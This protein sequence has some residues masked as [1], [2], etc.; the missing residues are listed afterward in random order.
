MFCNKQNVPLAAGY[1]KAMARKRGLDRALTLSIL[2]PDLADRAGDAALLSALVERETDLVALS[3]YP[4]N[5]ARSLALAA[6]LR[7]RRPQLLVVA[8]GPEVNANTMLDLLGPGHADVAVHGEGEITFSEILEALLDGRDPADVPGVTTLRDGAVY[9]A[10][11]RPTLRDLDEIPSPFLSGDLDAN[12]W[13]QVHIL[14]ERGCVYACKYCHWWP[15]KRSR[16]RFSLQRIEEEL[17]HLRRTQVEEVILLDASINTSPDFAAL[18]DLLARVNGDGRLKIKVQVLYDH[19]TREQLEAMARG[20]VRR[21]EIGLQSANPIALKRAQR[22]MEVESFERALALADGLPLDLQVD[23]M[24]GLPGDTVESVEGTARFIREAV[25][26][27]RVVQISPFLLSVGPATRFH[28]EAASEGLRFQA[29]PPH[30][31][32]STATMDYPTLR[33]LRRRTPLL[34]GAAE[35]PFWD[36]DRP[37]YA[38]NLFEP[39]LF[40]HSS[41]GRLARGSETPGAAGAAPGLGLIDG[42]HLECRNTEPGHKHAFD[43]GPIAHRLGQIAQVWLAAEDADACLEHFSDTLRAL[44]RPNP[45]TVWDV[46]L[47]TRGECDLD[48]FAHALSKVEFEV[49]NIDWDNHLVN[50]E[51]GQ[52]W[53]RLATRSMLV[54][55]LGSASRA[56]LEGASQHFPIIHAFT[57][58]SA[59]AAPSL[60]A[61]AAE[62]PGEGVLVDVADSAGGPAILAAVGEMARLACRVRG[63][64]NAALKALLEGETARRRGLP[65]PRVPWRDRVLWQAD[66]SGAAGATAIGHRRTLLDMAT[67]AMAL[68]R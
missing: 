10:P 4:W 60:F 38:L 29:G 58:E 15:D 5:Y 22:P 26:G 7:Q 20:G 33:A 32:L 17:R 66:A 14:F 37:H 2:E 16:G 43:P 65:R 12:S 25:R 46:V 23:F 55:P 42:V 35:H 9:T 47:E 27:K 62:L 24:L 56:W 6:A 59:A 57:I 28:R 48:A 39:D 30:R 50:P 31:V 1:L 3:L 19:F 8:G 54:V 49:N 44:T 13:R 45:F 53:A 52:G 64:R 63:F 40:T 51:E 68:V 61:A 11:L 41:A 21:L 36:L 34:L 67:I 18:C